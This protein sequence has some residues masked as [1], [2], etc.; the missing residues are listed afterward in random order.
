MEHT[1]RPGGSV[2]WHRATAGIAVSDGGP[3][4]PRV[5]I[6]VAAWIASAYALVVPLVRPRG[7][8]GWGHYAGRDLALGIVTTVVGLVASIDVCPRSWP[9]MRRGLL[10]G[11]TALCAALVAVV[12]CDVG[13][14]LA[15][16]QAWR[17]PA[18]TDAWAV[19][20]SADTVPDDRLGFARKPNLDWSGRPVEGGRWVH[21]RTDEHGF[22]NPPGLD[23][24][25]VVFV[26][27]SFTEAGA[28]PDEDTFVDRVGDRAGLRTV[29]L[30]RSRYG[31]QQ[32]EIVLEQSALA[33]HPRA[34]VWVLFEGNDLADAHRFAEWR[35]DPTGT[36]TFEVRYARMSPVLQ[37]V[38][39]TA[40]RPSD[41]PRRLRLPDGTTGDVYLDYGYVPD[42]SVRDPLGFDETRRSLAAGAEL[43]RSHGVALL[44]VLVPVKVHVLAPW[45]VFDDDADRAQFLPGTGDDDDR[46]FEHAVAGAARALGL[47][48]VDAL[49]MLR[50]RAAADDR[51]VYATYADSHL[52][53][54]GHAVIAD[55]VLDWLA[56]SVPRRP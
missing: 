7:I 18:S 43:C 54:D 52:E 9:R 32:E 10:A 2:G 44:V 12:V 50:A 30:G 49:P 36:Q 40:R 22:R 15:V 27:D 31:P 25:D 3:S 20:G 48:V 33:Y 24:A 38:R 42:A 14:V 1:V 5:G 8:Y 6:V 23:R 53:V 11:T 13:W 19:D 39:T 41:R 4:R 51:L 34:V 45:V 35:R 29:N 37:L 56:T 55:A 46:D 21:Y 26:G 17:H 16:R 47:P 28:I